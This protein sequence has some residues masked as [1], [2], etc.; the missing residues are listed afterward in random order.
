MSA[1]KWKPYPEYKPSK[2]E[3]I[4]EI[5]IHWNTTPLKGIVDQSRP[6]TYGIVQCGPKLKSGV[7][8]IRPADMS[9]EGGV[10]ME[11][12]QYTSQE[13]AAPYARSTI[14]EGDLVVSIGPS[15]GKVMTVPPKLE[16]GNLTQGTARIAV[17]ETNSPDYFFWVMRSMN[18]L[19][20]WNSLV[21]GATFR[22]LNL[23]PLSNSV[24]PVP[25]KS[26]QQ[27]ISLFIRKTTAIIDEMIF[28]L[29]LKKESIKEKR[30]TLI[31]QA[32]TKG[33]KSNKPSKAINSPWIGSIPEDWTNLRIKQIV[34][35]KVTDG[36]HVTPVQAD[37]GVPFLSATAVE[38]GKL[39]INKMWGYISRE[40]HDLYCRK[41][42]PQLED[43]FMVKSGATTGSIAFVDFEDEFSVWSPLALIRCDRNKMHPRFVFYSL[44]SDYLQKA[45][46]QTWSKGTQENIAMKAIEELPIL[47]PPLKEQIEI[48]NYIEDST[49]L[50]DEIISKTNTLIEKIKENRTALISAAV[51]GKIDVRSL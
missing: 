41:C 3:F 36:P 5:P 14:R 25:P 39:N 47:K 50:I 37:E 17:S 8:Y 29:N 31:T 44:Q 18:T 11:N 30:S 49:N 27:K 34:S 21:Q 9:D 32:V 23:E 2:S 38:N 4:G 6:I 1:S 15:Y 22:A 51:T 19:H 45:I 42:L 43:I 13:I 46:S 28:M 26:E 7:P 12:I 35:T 10:K 24:I 33:I 20:Q 16:G 40:D 48:A